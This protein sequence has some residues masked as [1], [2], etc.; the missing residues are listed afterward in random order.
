MV[1]INAM[2]LAAGLGTRLKPYTDK[3][4][5]ALAVVNGK[6][7]LERNVLYLQQFGITNVIVN[8][9]HFAEQIIKTIEKNKGWGSHIEISDE[10][11]ELLETGGGIQKAAWFLEQTQ[12]CVVL[13]CDILTDLRLDEMILHH[14]R[15]DAMATLATTSRQSS[16]YLLFND[17]DRLCG[18]R[19]VKTGEEK[20]PIT[21]TEST[22]FFQKAFSGIQILNREIF[23]HI[24]YKGKFSMIDVYLDL[25]SYHTILSYDHS[26]SKFIDI[27][28]PEKLA[29]AEIIFK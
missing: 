26:D 2:I 10:R 15:N 23:R 6:T 4:P 7:V 16:R 20:I 14:Q 11:G 28:T 3:H 21:I 19:N 17:L 13:N 9:H 8:M 5:K 18:W 25:C 24:H 1:P 12:N 29:A 22:N 27:G